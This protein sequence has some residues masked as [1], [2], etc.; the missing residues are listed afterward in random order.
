MARAA[1]E[2]VKL[3]TFRSREWQTNHSPQKSK[4]QVRQESLADFLTL[5]Q[6]AYLF[7]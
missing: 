5:T 2:C 6:L 3:L 1:L 4:A 7:S